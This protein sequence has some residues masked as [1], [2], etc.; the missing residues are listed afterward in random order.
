MLFR[1]RCLYNGSKID[2]DTFEAAEA[3]QDYIKVCAEV[4]KENVAPFVK[5]LFADYQTLSSMIESTL[6]SSAT[7]KT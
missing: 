7:T 2:N 6:K 5:S 1:S 3:R 4:A